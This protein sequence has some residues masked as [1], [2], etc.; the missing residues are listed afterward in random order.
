[1]KQYDNVV[2]EKNVNNVDEFLTTDGLSPHIGSTVL[3]EVEY[4]SIE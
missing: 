1:M 3:N 4:V 2:I